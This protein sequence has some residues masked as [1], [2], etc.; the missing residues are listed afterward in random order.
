MQQ[1]DTPQARTD[2]GL[3][4]NL[5]LRSGYQI[6]IDLLFP[7]RC[8]HCG[9]VDS[10]FCT[11]CHNELREEP[12]QTLIADDI[13]P[14]T[15]IAST[16]LHQDV[17]QAAVQG[18]KYYGQRELAAILAQRMVNMLKSVDWTF[19]IIIPVPMHSQRLKER[20]YNQANEISTYLAKLLD[21]MHE[22]SA[23]HRERATRSQVGLN[24]AERLENMEDAFSA[25]QTILKGKSLLLVDDVKTTG[26]TMAA[27]ATIA[28]AVGA[29]QIYGITVTTASS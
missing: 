19:D 22:D 12:I 4:S 2:S 5:M 25:D 17:L 1:F 28:Q 24:R 8:V 26:A 27:C 9:R 13:P 15:K 11:P 10:Q 14:L 16:G 23:I 7:P 18:L 3:F 29:S 20:G 6:I 21:K